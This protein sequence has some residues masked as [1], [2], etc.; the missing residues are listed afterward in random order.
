MLLYAAI[1][2]R[3]GRAVRLERGDFGRETAYDADPLDA[4]R[5][6]EEQ[7]AR[8]LHVVDLDGA[9]A[10]RPLNLAQVER[11]CS[12]SGLPVE[13]GGG[14]RSLADVTAAVAAGVDRVVLGT[15]ALADVHFLEAALAAH[16][17]RVAV[18]VDARGGRVAIEG[19]TQTAAAAPGEVVERLQ[20][21][22]VERFV[23][24]SIER[25]GTLGG[26]ALAEV[27]A[28][29]QAVRGSLVYSG[30]VSSLDDLRALARL[31]L[32]GLE[33]V[34]VGSAL[35]EGRFTAG[36]GQA[37]LDAAAQEAAPSS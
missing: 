13:L 18:S 15:A 25:D 6:W 29:A 24:S 27:R 35:F 23:Y 4:A 12:E 26:P 33:G 16:G 21:H 9:R 31:G 19:W 1:D 20:G 3:D 5:R 7:G 36:Q 8:Y 30:G 17:S 34:I 37:A 28:I 14:L 2:I 11:I 32:P 22:G 10:G